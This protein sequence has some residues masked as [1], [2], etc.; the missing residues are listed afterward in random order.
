VALIRVT[1]ELLSVTRMYR[2]RSPAATQAEEVAKS[3]IAAVASA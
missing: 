2:H 1:T 3:P